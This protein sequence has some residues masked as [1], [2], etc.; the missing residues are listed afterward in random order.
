[1]VAAGDGFRCFARRPSS[2]FWPAV[3]Q[4]ESR[5]VELGRQ[6][7]EVFV[8]AH[9][10]TNNME[11]AYREAEALRLQEDLLREEEARRAESEEKQAA[12]SAAQAEKRK[13]KKERKKKLKEEEKRREDE[14][15][16]RREE[17]ERAKREEEERR[18]REVEDKRRAEEEERRRREEEE[19][20]KKAEERRKVRGEWRVAGG[21]G[22]EAE[23]LAGCN[24]GGAAACSCGSLV[25]PRQ[26]IGSEFR[27]E[28]QK[29]EERRRREEE[30]ARR[31]QEAETRARAEAE[32]RE[33]AEAERRAAEARAREEE[34]RA[35]EQEVR[36]REEQRR[37]AED[38]AA[39]ATRAEAAAVELRAQLSAAQ[40]AA[41][42]HGQRAEDLAKAVAALEARVGERDKEVAQLRW[43]AALPGARRRPLGARLPLSRALLC[44]S[45]WQARLRQMTGGSAL[46]WLGC[47][48]GAPC[49]CPQGGRGAFIAAPTRRGR[50]VAMRLAGPWREGRWGGGAGGAGVGSVVSGHR[51][52]TGG[53]ERPAAGD[54]A[55]GGAC[56]HAHAHGGAGLRAGRQPQRHALRAHRP[57]RYGRPGVP[58]RSLSERRTRSAFPSSRSLHKPAGVS[59]ACMPRCPQAPPHAMSSIQRRDKPGSLFCLAVTPLRSTRHRPRHPGGPRSAGHGLGAGRGC[60]D[61]GAR[62]EGRVAH[63]EHAAAGQA[64][65]G[66]R[67]QAQQ[68]RGVQQ[69]AQHRGEPHEGCPGVHVGAGA[70]GGGGGAGA[71]TGCRGDVAERGS[72]ARDCVGGVPAAPGDAAAAGDRRRRAA[73]AGFRGAGRRGRA[74]PRPAAGG[75]ARRARAHARPGHGRRACPPGHAAGV[76]ACRFLPGSALVGGRVRRALPRR[77]DH[78]HGARHAAPAGHGGGD[79]GVPV[80]APPGPAHVQAARRGAAPGLAGHGHGRLPAHGPHQR[81]A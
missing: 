34:A 22:L 26:L 4:D 25:V 72:A 69:R 30:E 35:R 2:Q 65:R 55:A 52:R 45:A 8:L 63:A 50:I 76:G 53:H 57:C 79:A 60:G 37:G 1:M 3:D 59:C 32:A 54:G 42:G 20:A 40:Q 10:W 74:E 6:A 21:C 81:L 18:K 51:G 15:R 68:A 75:A 39:E 58:A 23:A 71:A 5:L 14:E 9:V 7:V 66:G 56:D 36:A 67:Q 47:P 13:A 16:L 49:L 12:K 11:V 38:R 17:E 70:A 24:G 27:P 41:A 28:S 33:V 64:G 44:D 80:H 48:R 29:E 77:A 19:A 78:A 62:R 31:K 61:G 43:G 46:T 73:Q